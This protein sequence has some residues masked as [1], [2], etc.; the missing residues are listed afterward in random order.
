MIQEQA[1][2]FLEETLKTVKVYEEGGKYFISVNLSDL[3]GD[4]LWQPTYNVM[5][6]NGTFLGMAKK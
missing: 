6:T 5:D 2:V 1:K 4:Q 3:P